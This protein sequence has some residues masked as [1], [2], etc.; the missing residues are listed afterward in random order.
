M[1]FNLLLARLIERWVPPIGQFVEVEG[2]RLHYIDTG[3][4][5]GQD[6]PPLLFVH[7]WLGQLNHFSY[8][9]GGAVSG[10]TRRS[11]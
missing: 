6:G 3:E 9:P 2:V 4:K 7:G 5:P 10:A 1:A 11:G 8:C